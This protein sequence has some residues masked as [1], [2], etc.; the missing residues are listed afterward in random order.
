MEAAADL[1]SADLIVV[2]GKPAFTFSGVPHLD[3]RTLIERNVMID[4]Q[5]YFVLSVETYALY[6]ATGTNFGLMVSRGW[7]LPASYAKNEKL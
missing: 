1:T 3:P 2:N 4:G 7:V 6:D 5:P